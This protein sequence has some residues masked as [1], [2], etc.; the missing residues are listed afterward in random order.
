L[1]ALGI[2][3]LILHSTLLPGVGNYCNEKTGM[4]FALWCMNLHVNEGCADIFPP[5]WTETLMLRDGV[6]LTAYILVW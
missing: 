1:G 4:A 2:K 3:V 5:R 6:L